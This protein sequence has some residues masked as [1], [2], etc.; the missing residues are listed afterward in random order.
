MEKAVVVVL[1][2]NRAISRDGDK[3][4]IEALKEL[5]DHLSQ[6]WS[7][8]QCAAMGG[9]GNLVVSSSLVILE[10]KA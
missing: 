3:C 6:G 7:V 5:N 2:V 10:K 9:T 8:K 4:R 1:D